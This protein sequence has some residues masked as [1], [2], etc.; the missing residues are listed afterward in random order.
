[1]G[2]YPNLT[3]NNGG[4]EGV[5]FCSKEKMKDIL[6]LED[7]LRASEHWQNQYSCSDNLKWFKSVTHQI[8]SR[9]LIDNG[10]EDV[11]ERGINALNRA[12]YEY[13]DDP[14]M[15][16]LT[17]YMRHDRSKMGHLQP[18]DPVPNVPLLTIDGKSIKF[19]DYINSLKSSNGKDKPLFVIA[20]SIS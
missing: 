5:Q 3:G 1:M 6:I 13:R 12:R 14:S 2:S 17:V 18:G 11:L 9:A 16:K 19:H 4:G 7:E 15:N 20:G 10:F 8:Q